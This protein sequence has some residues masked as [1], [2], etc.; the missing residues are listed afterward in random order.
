M[1]IDTNN[2]MKVA[3]E[4]KEHYNSERRPYVSRPF[5]RH[6]PEETVW[7]VIPSKEWPAHR[8]AK[9]IIWRE[10]NQMYVGVNIEKGFGN[11]LFELNLAPKKL[12]ID[13]KWVWNNFIDDLKN[14]KLNEILLDAS[15]YV[16]EDIEL[17][18]AIGYVDR[19]K[20]KDEDYKENFN[21]TIIYKYNDEKV[22]PINKNIYLEDEGFDELREVNDLKGVYNIIEEQNLAF[23][24][25]DFNIVIPIDIEIDFNG[26]NNFDYYDL[27]NNFLSKFHYL[28]ER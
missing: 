27:E 23:Y 10:N 6:K 7:W 24:W 28:I 11:E 19:N 22:M 4:I 17:H 9:F 2:P 13:D 25:L 20:N 5:N 8:F 15:K 1:I 18:L 3:H 14:N 21:N 16:D 12:V 26:D